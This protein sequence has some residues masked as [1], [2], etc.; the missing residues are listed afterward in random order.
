[1][2]GNRLGWGISAVLTAIILLLLRWIAQVSAISPPS[3]GLAARTGNVALNLGNPDRQEL[4]DPIQLP[5]NPQRVLPA[6]TETADAGELYRKAIEEYKTDKYTYRD[7]FETDK[8]KTSSY[9]DL[10]AIVFIVQ[11]KDRTGMNLFAARPEE[12]IGY[13]KETTAPIDALFDVGHAASQLALHLLKTK[14]QPGDA[15]T[16]AEAVFSLGVK[17]CQ[18]RLRW[19]EFEAGAELLRDAAFVIQQLDPARPDID[20]VDPGMKVLLRD[21]CIPLWTVIGS[22]D[23]NVVGRTAGDVFYVAKNSKERLW[24][25]EAI[26]KLGRYKFNAGNEGRAADQRWAGLAVKRLANDPTLDPVLRAAAKAA[27]ELTEARFN[28]IGG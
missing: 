26:L 9:K 28:M 11:A 7:L 1:M 25:I 10:P 5:F 12:V 20:R 4:L 8:P 13:D 21:R 2:F 6:M 16:L 18:E 17:M 23:Q 14:Q 27:N 15:L 24:R 3:Q 22:I 19:R